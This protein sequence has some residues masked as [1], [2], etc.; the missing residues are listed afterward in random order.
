[1]PNSTPAA[2]AKTIRTKLLRRERKNA[3]PLVDM[4]GRTG[5]IGGSGVGLAGSLSVGALLVLSNGG[6]VDGFGEWVVLST[7]ALAATRPP[8]TTRTDP[9]ITLSKFGTSIR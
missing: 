4:A 5:V 6:T 3:L 2:R 8:I 9:A 1:M 7:S